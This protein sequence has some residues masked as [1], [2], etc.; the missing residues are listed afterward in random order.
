M[1]SFEILWKSSSEHDLRKI[2]HQ[3]IPQIIKAVEGLSE[4]P[5][6]N[7]CRKLRESESSYR[8]RIGDYRVIYQVDSQ[9]KVVTIFHVRH[10]KEAYRK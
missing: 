3:Y 9:S 7:N 8:I 6:P 2:A 10:R 4:D 5:F 1:A